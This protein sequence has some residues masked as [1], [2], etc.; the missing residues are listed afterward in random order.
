M[1]HRHTIPGGAAGGGKVGWNRIRQFKRWYKV[2][3]GARQWQKK[4]GSGVWEGGSGGITSCGSAG[5]SGIGGK[6]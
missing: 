5:S 2:V 4:A 6:G 1:W 3:W